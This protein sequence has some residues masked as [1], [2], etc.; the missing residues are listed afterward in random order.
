V[1]FEARFPAVPLGVSAARGEAAAVARR[2]GLDEMRV[3][4]VALA[5]SEA[6]TN[7]VVHAGAGS[8]ELRIE[9]TDGELL[10]VVSDDGA[11]MRP[12]RDS[13]GLGLGLPIIATVTD[14]METRTEGGR[15]EVLMVF[16]CPAAV[17]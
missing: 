4:D 7:V 16:P 9:A 6:A 14:R 13:P 11:G 15:T 3:G 17:G 10:V 5:V 2:C 8:I 12:R 1:R